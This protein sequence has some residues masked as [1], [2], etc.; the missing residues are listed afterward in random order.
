MPGEPP[1]FESPAE[2]TLD[3]L[4][5][6]PFVETRPVE[7]FDCGN[8]DLND[9]L[10]TEEVEKY[11]NEGLGTTH[12]VYFKGELV[13]YFTVSFGSLYVEYLKSW[14]S[15]SKIAQMKIDSIP[16]V[17][18]GRLGVATA[19]HGRGI[20]RALIRYIAGLA[21]ETRGKLAVRLIILQSY[22]ESFEFY[23]KCGFQF[24]TLTKRE[25]KRRNKSRTMFFDLHAITRVA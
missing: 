4:R 12:L 8:R 1:D 22:P 14:K 3:A 7:T 23:L 25:R 19:Y 9:F 11:E 10:T 24:T 18:I 15:F 16:A 2:I 21:L 13:A 20:G 5:I 6:E 17:M